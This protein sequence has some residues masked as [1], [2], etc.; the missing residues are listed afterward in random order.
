[1]DVSLSRTRILVGSLIILSF[2]F[3]SCGNRYDL[4]TERGRRSR[5]DD[6][7]FHLSRGQC[8]AA[9]EAIDPLFN[10]T[11][12]TD[13]IRIIKASTFA[14]FA[15]FN[16]LTFISNLSS[17][18]NQFKAVAKSIDNV[19]NDSARARMYEAVDVITKSGASMNAGLR[20]R[21]ENSYMVFLSLG[22]LGVILRNYGS[23]SS[24]GSK[25]TNLVY[26]TAANPATEMSNLDACAIG[27]AYSHLSDSFPN[28]DLSDSTTRNIV[29]SLNAVCVTA[30]LSSCAQLD[31]V[32]T[33]CD[34]TNQASVR[35]QALVGGINTAW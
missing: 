14:C 3:L 31:R 25:G 35:A 12:E 20:S 24:D 22:V 13:E 7:N 18:T 19:P 27:A 1:M 29:N 9:A 28:S 30:G 4:S 34:G 26:D 23:P 6:A 15:K 32:R 21:S 8:S 5:I 11:Y 33:A 2:S 10:S 16:M 17:E